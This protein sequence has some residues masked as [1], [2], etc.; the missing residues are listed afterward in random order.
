[1]R[2]YSSDYLNYSHPSHHHVPV[3]LPIPFHSG[4]RA[5]KNNT[6]ALRGHGRPSSWMTRWMACP[7]SLPSYLHYLS[8]RDFVSL[9]C[10]PPIYVVSTFYTYIHALFADQYAVYI[11]LDLQSSVLSPSCIPFPQ[12]TLTTLMPT[13]STLSSSSSSTMK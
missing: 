4:R 10:H 7:L 9:S 1:M 3:R 11:S 8:L 13:S 2:Y 12:P 5:Q 6:K